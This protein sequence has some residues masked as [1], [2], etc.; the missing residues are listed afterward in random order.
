MFQILNGQSRFNFN[1]KVITKRDKNAINNVIVEYRLRNNGKSYT[2]K[3]IKQSRFDTHPHFEC[4]PSHPRRLDGN[5]TF[6]LHV[7]TSSVS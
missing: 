7:R 6:G 2:I 4:I 1:R 5:R 3:T